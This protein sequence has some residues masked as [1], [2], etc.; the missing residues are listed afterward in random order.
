MRCRVESFIEV[1]SAR[2][3]GR[4]AGRERAIG[5]SQAAHR[6]L[7]AAQ[8][9]EADADRASRAAPPAPRARA[10]A[11]S[12]RSARTQRALLA[13]VAVAEAA[14]RRTSPPSTCERAPDAD[15]RRPGAPA[16]SR[17]RRRA[18]SRPARRAA[19]RASA[20]RCTRATAPRRRRSARSRPGAPSARATWSRQR[21]PYSSLARS[22]IGGARRTIVIP[23]ESIL[24]RRPGAPDLVSSIPHPIATSAA[25]CTICASRS[26]TAAT[27]A[28]PT[29]CRPRSTASSTAS[30]RARSCSRFEEI[31]RLARLFVAL[32]VEK[33]RITGGEPLLRHE[34]P[35]AD[36]EAR[37]ASRACATSRSPPTA[38]C[39]PRQ[40]EALAAAG[41]RRVTVSLDSHDEAVFRRMSGRDVGPARV[42]EGIEAAAGARASRRSRSTAWCSAA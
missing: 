28:V 30:C 18:R 2:R 13:A 26:P 37:R 3:F 10:R 16:G 14:R 20:S 22:C 12:S 5:S 24:K 6:A 9:V 4:V 41:L 42:L 38:C 17:L 25:G 15:L 29:A 35:A 33:I 1:S 32:G 34:L 27:S 19:A 7:V 21:R 23:N 40:A 8:V 11:A 36:R 39:S 31:E